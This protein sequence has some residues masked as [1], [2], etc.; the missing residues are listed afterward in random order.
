MTSRNNQIN[1]VLNDHQGKPADTV[2]ESD[3]FESVNL[4]LQHFIGMEMIR[5]KMKEIYAFI[6]INKRRKE[7]G[8]KTEAQSLH[9][10][11]KGNPGTGKTTVARALANWFAELDILTNNH[12]IEVDRA[13]LVGE[14]IGQTA[15]KTRALIKRAQGGILFI[16]EAYALA[17]G[18]DKDFGKEAIDML[19]TH[20]ENNHQA[21]ILILAGYPEQMDGFLRT[22]PGLRSRFPFIIDF[23][24]YQPTELIEIAKK[25]VKMRDYHLTKQAELKLNQL[26][27][28]E[29]QRR[30][31]LHFSNA[32]Y[33]RNTIEQSIRNQAIRL[34]K[35]RVYDVKAFI[36]LTA[37]DIPNDNE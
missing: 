36:L 12:V 24:D 10:L 31:R 33:V 21:F 35:Q 22:N 23:P 30:D 19:V 8:L 25:M 15:H 18:G 29:I 13:D 34:I 2:P 9:M 1:I 32:R 6:E 26:I 17:R 27:K 3:P 4:A 5:D 11:F 14:Y 28:K 16:D 20:M 37:D 7:V